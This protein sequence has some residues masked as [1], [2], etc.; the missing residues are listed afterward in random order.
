MTQP[1]LP[2]QSGSQNPDDRKCG[3][4][5]FDRLHSGSKASTRNDRRRKRRALI[6]APVRIRCLDVTAGGPD[7]I[8]TTVDVS[9]N[10]ILF[11]SSNRGF[12]RG[13]EVAVTFPYTKSASVPAP[14]Q[15]GSVVRVSAL[16]DGRVAIGICFG[17]DPGED[18]VKTVTPSAAQSPD[19]IMPLPDEEAS[20][21]PLILVVETDAALRD[22]LKGYLSGEG[23]NVIAVDNASDAREVLNMLTPALLIAEIEGE[24][25]PGF[26]LCVHVKMTPRLKHIPVMLTTESA[27]PSDY[28]SAHSLGAVV[29]LAKPFRQERLGHVVRLL[30][31]PQAVDT[32]A[33]PPRTPDRTRRPKPTTN[34]G[35][36]S[37]LRFL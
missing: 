30:A 13:M 12:H 33:A 27:Y 29:C 1:F 35:A 7:E 21:K 6:S 10:G 32:H 11:V 16:S 3:Q 17:L 14:E 28:S 19:Q 31:P 20:R 9:R 34:R 15:P 5:E 26:D 37:K 22:S 24:G 8:C 23:Y 4:E 25:L 36:F 2:P 18:A